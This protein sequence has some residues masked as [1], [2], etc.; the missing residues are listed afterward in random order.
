[1]SDY[2]DN[3]NKQMKLA[4]MFVTGYGNESYAWRLAD[5]RFC[6]KSRADF[7]EAWHLSS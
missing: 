6:G 7:A 3:S 1:M 4:M 2:L 5:K